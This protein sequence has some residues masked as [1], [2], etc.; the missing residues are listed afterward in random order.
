LRVFENK[1][2]RR[3]CGHKKEAIRGW[4]KL[5]TE[6]IHNLYSS[7]YVVGVIKTRRIRWARHVANTDKMRSACKTLVRK[8]QRKRPLA[9]PRLKWE[10]IKRG[11]TETRSEVG[12]WLKP[13][14]N[15]KISQP[16][17]ELSTSQRRLFVI[18]LLNYR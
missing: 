15:E 17:K 13:A 10:D 4:R 11:L 14:Q 1:V 6:E 7:P 18:K 3:V 12:N 5:Y 16:A 9:M 2:L 8:P